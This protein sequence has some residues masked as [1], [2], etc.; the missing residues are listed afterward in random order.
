MFSMPIPKF[1]EMIQTWVETSEEDGGKRPDAGNGAPFAAKT[2]PPK[3]KPRSEPTT[4]TK[5]S[6]SSP[7]K[8]KPR[9]KEL[10]EADP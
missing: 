3:N 2:S 9:R 8:T 6:A 7:P 1:K 10:G 4:R 5:P